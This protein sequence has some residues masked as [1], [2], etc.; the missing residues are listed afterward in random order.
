MILYEEVCQSFIKTRQGR[1]EHF[2]GGG[3]LTLGVSGDL[4][5]RLYLSL[6]KHGAN[7]GLSWSSNRVSKF[8][9]QHLR[10]GGVP[11]QGVPHQPHQRT[12]PDYCIVIV[13]LQMVLRLCIVRVLQLTYKVRQRF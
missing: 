7:D 8:V 9:A 10:G 5:H 4:P 11:H 1:L 2:L 12:A 6:W 13:Q 3:W